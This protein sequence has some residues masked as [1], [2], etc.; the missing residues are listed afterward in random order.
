MQAAVAYVLKLNE[1]QF[2]T[3]F[4]DLC[5]W[6]N[7]VP[8]YAASATCSEIRT[9]AH[10]ARRAA[11]FGLVSQLSR[12][13]RTVFTPYFEDLLEGFVEVLT[14]QAEDSVPLVGSRKRSKSKKKEATTPAD[15]PGASEAS[16]SRWNLY[17]VARDRAVSCIH[18][19]RMHDT[20]ATISQDNYIML[21]TPLVAQL[22]VAGAESASVH[23]SEGSTVRERGRE[24]G[25][26][27]DLL[28]TV[29]LGS[30]TVSQLSDSAVGVLACIV[31][32]MS[33]TTDE[34]LWKKTNHQ[35]WEL[36]SS[37]AFLQLLVRAFCVLGT[38]GRAHRA[39]M[40]SCMRQ[41]CLQLL[42]VVPAKH[43]PSSGVGPDV[44]FDQRLYS[45]GHV[46]SYALDSATLPSF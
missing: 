39:S 5:A 14:K 36:V 19:F 44:R 43:L 22:A 35:V 12:A 17:T 7:T 40:G 28:H 24:S 10:A 32:L 4:Q 1:I 13:L 6:A 11:W 21:L 27:A 33:S 30:R 9:A 41:C 26:D 16:G 45:A 18:R 37:F 3:L 31:A 2:K 38:L 20:I 23:G 34:A 46:T 15:L 42:A 29:Q 8:S 25:S